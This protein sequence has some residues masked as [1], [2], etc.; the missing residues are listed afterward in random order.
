MHHLQHIAEKLTVNLD[1]MGVNLEL[2]RGQIMAESIMMRLAV[3]VGHEPAHEIVADVT[4]RASAQHVDLSTIIMNDERI[5]AVMGRKEI[6]E[7][8]NPWAYLGECEAIVDAVTSET[9]KLGM[10]SP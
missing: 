9:G 6:E 5:M 7:A 10:A 8:L 3:H 2:T 1:R 4:R